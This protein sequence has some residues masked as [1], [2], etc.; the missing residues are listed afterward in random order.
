MKIE[1]FLVEQKPSMLPPHL[2]YEN[3]FLPLQ[4]LGV[5]Q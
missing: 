2:K 5:V 4:I 3:M 1:Y